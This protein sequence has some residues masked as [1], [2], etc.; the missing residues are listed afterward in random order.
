MSDRYFTLLERHQKLDEALRLAR[1]KRWV[2]PFEIARIKKLKLAV[3]SR[4]ARL[5]PRKSATI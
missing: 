1:R 3:K 4:L 2:D 5:L